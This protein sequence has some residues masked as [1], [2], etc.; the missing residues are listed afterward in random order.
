MITCSTTFQGAV[1]TYQKRNQTFLK[2]SIC[3][4]TPLHILASSSLTASPPLCSGFPGGFIP[5]VGCPKG[6][7]DMARQPAKSPPSGHPLQCTAAALS[8]QRKHAGQEGT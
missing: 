7:Q 4:H 8:G 3:A 1:N 6:A 5:Q 2:A